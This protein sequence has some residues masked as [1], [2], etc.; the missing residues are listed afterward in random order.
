MYSLAVV[1]GP[2]SAPGLVP[3]VVVP[4]LI[5]VFLIRWSGLGLPLGS[6]APF[7][8]MYG[9][10][11]LKVGVEWNLTAVATQAIAV[12]ARLS[13]AS[14]LPGGDSACCPLRLLFQE[15][16]VGNRINVRLPHRRQ[17]SRRGRSNGRVRRGSRSCVA[18]NGGA[19]PRGGRI[20]R[21]VLGR[22]GL[23]GLVDVLVNGRWVLLH[24]LLNLF[25]FFFL[26]GRNGALRRGRSRD[27]GAR[28]LKGEPQC[29]HQLRSTQWRTTANERG[30][31]VHVRVVHECKGVLE[32]LGV[33]DVLLGRH[34]RSRC[35]HGCNGNECKKS[36]NL[37]KECRK[38]NAEVISDDE[39]R[40]PCTVSANTAA[41]SRSEHNASSNQATTC[42][43]PQPK[44]M[45]KGD[46][47]FRMDNRSVQVCENA[48]ASSRPAET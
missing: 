29:K 7:A 22:N 2:S 27:P 8:Q 16:R 28:R 39:C 44:A 46:T 24:L 11:A 5:A 47:F 30:Q 4:L 36:R 9:V 38:V 25:P 33:T 15:C 26:L 13:A 41:N 17:C 35:S 21:R 42:N 48:A 23:V 31:L 32:R 18:R 20:F 37:K 10:L 45:Q 12:T 43:R 19:S 14:N 3:G 1:P 6:K 40:Q 34:R